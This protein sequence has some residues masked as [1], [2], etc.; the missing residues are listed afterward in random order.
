MNDSRHYR[1]SVKVYLNFV[2]TPQAAHVSV[3]S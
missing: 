2:P 3:V 1:D